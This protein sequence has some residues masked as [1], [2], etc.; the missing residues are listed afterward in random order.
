[1]KNKI[2]V[3]LFAIFVILLTGTIYFQIYNTAVSNT[4]LAYF[5]YFATF[6]FF[7]VTVIYGRKNI[8]S[9]IKEGYSAE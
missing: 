6:V 9:Q 2:G 1:M 5:F 8:K 4:S 3:A 7:I